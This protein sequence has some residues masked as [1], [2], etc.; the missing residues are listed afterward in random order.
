MKH[1]TVEELRAFWPER[2]GQECCVIDVRTPAEYAEAHVPGARLICL[3]TLP[4]R[5]RDIPKDQDVY[6]ICRLGARSAQAL[7]YLSAAH[8]H[9]RLV[10]VSG[11]TMAWIA[12]GY[13]VE[14]GGAS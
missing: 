7:K 8:G 12:A 10:N 9:T 4:E 1:I 5:A 11:G 6:L 2:A 3:D 14:T 13:P